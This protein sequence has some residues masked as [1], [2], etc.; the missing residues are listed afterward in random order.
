MPVWQNVNL[1]QKAAGGR[2]KDFGK[3]VEHTSPRN[4]VSTIFGTH[5]HANFVTWLETYDRPEEW[6]LFGR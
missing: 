3:L 5:A 1:K 2:S 6:L 4:G